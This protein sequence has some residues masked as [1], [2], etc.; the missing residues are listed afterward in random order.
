MAFAKTLLFF[1]G[2]TTYLKTQKLWG[3]RVLG[4][5]VLGF[6]VL[7]FKVFVYSSTV[8]IRVWGLR[9]EVL[10]NRRTWF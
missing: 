10:Q 2:A 3:F 7:G 1:S 8:G 6:R 4:F 5:R 9:P